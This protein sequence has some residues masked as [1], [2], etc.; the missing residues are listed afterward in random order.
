MA[1]MA[2]GT[3]DRRVAR[4]GTGAAPGNGRA[5]RRAQGVQERPGPARAAAPPGPPGRRRPGPRPRR[6]FVSPVG[7]RGQGRP[8]GPARPCACMARRML[9][10]I[11][12]AALL[13]HPRTRR[14][15]MPRPLLGRPHRR[16]ERCAPQRTG[17]RHPLPVAPL[18]APGARRRL[19]G[20]AVRAFPH[21]R[22]PAI[23]RGATRTA[24]LRVRRSRRGANC[25]W[26][27]G[28]RA[29]RTGPALHGDHLRAD[30][31]RS[32]ACPGGV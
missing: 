15:S 11:P 22:R 17:L 26:P 29:P 6:V 32:P 19:K 2:G 16:P 18:C 24:A 31:R 23:P 9:P 3:G 7:R 4:P 8:A 13:P 28:P 27:C 21:G 12:L 1:R 25:A 20:P 30:R 10:H 14:R 5:R